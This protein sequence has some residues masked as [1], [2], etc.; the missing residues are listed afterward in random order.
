MRT[1]LA[2]PFRD[3]DGTRL[4]PFIKTVELLL[5]FYDW[6]EVVAVDSGHPKFNRAATRNLAFQYGR[7]YDYDVVVCNDADT[8]G[9]SEGYHKA[10]DAAA[11]NGLINYPFT[12]VF[13][14]I[15][16]AIATVGTQPASILR[17][18]AFSKCFSEGG[19]YVATPESFAGAGWQDPR[20]TGWGCEDRA[21]ISSNKTLLGLPLKQPEDLFCLYHTRDEDVWLQSDV[22]LLFRYD[23]AFGNETEMRA[24]TEERLDDC[25]TYYLGALPW[26]TQ[27]CGPT[28][29][30]IPRDLP[31][32]HKAGYRR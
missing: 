18:R 27:E 20:F 10:I 24:L 25:E 13:E 1:L 29:R 12:V 16:K 5:N 2:I 3:T 21:F 26:E 31:A 11:T 14:L 15:P 9:Q 17:N 22:D 4:E 6:T 28:V 30:V 19:V 23:N 32:R 7:D 8:I